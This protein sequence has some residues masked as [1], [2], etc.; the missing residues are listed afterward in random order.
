M[1]AVSWRPS[2]VRNNGKTDGFFRC[3]LPPVVTRTFGV[4][5]L[6]AV[7]VSAGA[8]AGT[9][10]GKTIVLKGASGAPACQA[11]HGADGAGQPSLG[12]PRLAGLSAVYIVEQLK[13]FDD[14]SRSNDIMEPIA[15]AL[16][17]KDRRAVAEYMSR[18]TPPV[19]K[20]SGLPDKEL[21]SKGKAIAMDGHWSKGVPG[22]NQCHGP[23]GSGVGAAFPRL[24]G[25]SARYIENQ[26]KAWKE[27][28]RSNDPLHLMT[29][30]ASKLTEADMKA[31]AAY[32]ASVD[33][34]DPN[35]TKNMGVTP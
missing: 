2:K 10:D 13:S 34:V 4:F 7:M 23:A 35:A 1:S 20:P 29:G 22:C 17:Q 30:L 12:Y 21:I 33:P 31:V 11:C 8:A 32:Y 9:E 6:T 26:L 5:M 19:A 24:A 16:S 28:T 18:Q 3:V 14:G 25:Q 15:K 27:A